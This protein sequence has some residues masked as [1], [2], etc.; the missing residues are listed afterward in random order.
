MAPELTNRPVYNG[1]KSDIYSL[2]R[3]LYF[4]VAPETSWINIDSKVSKEC[5]NFLMRTICRTPEKRMTIQEMKKHKWL[6]FAV[7]S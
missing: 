2:G 5:K 7:P 6:E 4:M 3:T 1:F